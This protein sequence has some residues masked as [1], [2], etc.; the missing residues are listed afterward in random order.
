MEWKYLYDSVK[1]YFILAIKVQSDLYY[2]MLI[3]LCI[4]EVYNMIVW[5]I[6]RKY[7][8]CYIETL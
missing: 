4:F 7:K 8:G 3:L 5:D 1:K 6:C 2:E